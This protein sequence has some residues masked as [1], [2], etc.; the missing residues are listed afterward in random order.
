MH[1]R[2]PI[3]TWLNLLEMGAIVGAQIAR[4][5][6]VIALGKGRDARSIAIASTVKISTNKSTI[7]RKKE[8][9]YNEF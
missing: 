2:K 3:L 5:N 6:I 9:N 8:L 7:S 4:K 1:F